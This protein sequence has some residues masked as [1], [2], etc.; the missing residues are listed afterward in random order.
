MNKFLDFLEK[1]DAAKIYY[2]L[3]KVNEN[4]LIEVAVP[5]QR[6]EIEFDRDENMQI[7]IF[8]SEGYIYD[9]EKID[10]LLRNYAD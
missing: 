9:E 1:L 8:T 5:G 4:I 10:A 6:W 7:E 2:R 3:N